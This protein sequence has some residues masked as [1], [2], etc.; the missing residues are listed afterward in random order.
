MPRIS[1]DPVLAARTATA[2]QQ[3]SRVDDFVGKRMRERRIGL[4][5]TQYQLGDKIDL[6]Y[7]QILKYE[8][9][10]NCISAG[11]LYEIA[12]ALNTPIDY[13]YEGYDDGET[14][15][16]SARRGKN[17]QL[18]IARNLDEIHNEKHLEAISL[19]ARALAG[20]WLPKIDLTEPERLALAYVARRDPN[21]VYDASF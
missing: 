18:E 11:R 13:F 3:I 5:L 20:R 19:V 8:H 9:G 12:C 17:R 4:G 10:I 2:K 7:Q 6:S 21:V 14:H 15:R 16:V 1:A